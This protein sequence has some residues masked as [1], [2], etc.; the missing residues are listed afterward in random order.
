MDEGFHLA[1]RAPD[2][3]AVDR[4]HAEALRLGGTDDGAPGLRPHYGPSYYAAF[5]MDFDRHRL[6]VVHDPE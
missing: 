4:F 5:V 2:R 1:F 6:E 3:S